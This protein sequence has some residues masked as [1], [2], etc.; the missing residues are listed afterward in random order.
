MRKPKLTN[1]KPDFAK[2]YIWNVGIADSLADFL[3]LIFNFRMRWNS[4]SGE[5]NPL[6][7]IVAAAFASEMSLFICSSFYTSQARRNATYRIQNEEIDAL[8]QGKLRK[9]LPCKPRYLFLLKW[10]I[11]WFSEWLK[12]VK[13]SEINRNCRARR[14]RR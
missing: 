4:Q 14:I 9:F 2:C 5:F 3:S 12:E 1:P 6:V 13:Q 7:G 11:N 8:L 10:A